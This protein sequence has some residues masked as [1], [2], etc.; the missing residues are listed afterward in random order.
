MTTIQPKINQSNFQATKINKSEDKTQNKEKTGMSTT[1]KVLV[2][3]TALAAIVV[4]GI[5]LKG[6]IK[7]KNIQSVEQTANKVSEKILSN[8]KKITKTVEKT[9]DGAEKVIMNVFD[10][11]GALQLTREKII[12]RSVNPK[13]GRKYITID[14]NYTSPLE[15]MNWIDMLNFRKNATVQ[16]KKY[17]SPEGKK[18]FETVDQRAGMPK[19]KVERIKTREFIYP[20]GTSKIGFT[21]FDHKGNPDVRSSRYYLK[22]ENSVIRKDSKVDF[23]T[24]GV[25]YKK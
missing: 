8:G 12:T 5:A 13:N 3:A 16:T 11:K 25:S 20:D 21:H 18:F 14:K 17:Y 7:P 22:I 2:G 23:T 19:D 15:D 24:N 6:K 1:G 4:A 9:K 10:D